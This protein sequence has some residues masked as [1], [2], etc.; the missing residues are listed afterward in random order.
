MKMDNNEYNLDQYVIT[1]QLTKNIDKTKMSLINYIKKY[2]D[3]LDFTKVNDENNFIGIL[4]VNPSNSVVDVS[5]LYSRVSALSTKV[6]LYQ[7]R[8][9]NTPDNV[10]SFTQYL[11]KSVGTM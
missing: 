1:K 8:L 9:L 4:P 6:F 7:L 10:A 5:I 2:K 3:Y 11:N